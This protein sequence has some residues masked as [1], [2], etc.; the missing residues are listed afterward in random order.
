MKEVVD[1]FENDKSGVLGF[2]QMKAGWTDIVNNFQNYFLNNYYQLQLKIL[3]LYIPKY[4]YKKLNN[5][6]Q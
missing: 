5:N 3:R 1:Y 4:S 6:L 2:T